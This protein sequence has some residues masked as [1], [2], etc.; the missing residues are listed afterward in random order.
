MKGL[1]PF[2][3]AQYVQKSDVDPYVICK[4]KSHLLDP[5]WVLMRTRR[6]GMTN[7]L[8]AHEKKKRVTVKLHV[9]HVH[10]NGSIYDHAARAVPIN[11]MSDPSRK[12]HLPAISS[13][14]F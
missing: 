12:A 10:A 14:K 11:S 6:N 2:Y 8:G 7:R 5:Q 1:L 3:P 4:K 9:P 13:F